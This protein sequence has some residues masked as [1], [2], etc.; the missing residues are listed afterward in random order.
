MH[1]KLLIPVLAAASLG[2]GGCYIGDFNGGMRYHRDFHYSF[3]ISAGGRVDVETFNGGIEITPWDQN[4][5]DI[6]GTKWGP[7]E[8][9]A[10][11]LR[12]ETDRTG[13]SVAVRA[14]RPSE[15]RNNLGARFSLKVPHGAVLDRIITTN[16][17]IRT[18]E[19]AGPARMQTS[20][21]S[22]HVQS[23][24]GRLDAQTSN[25]GIDV[26]DIEGDVT[27]HTSNGH[28]RAERCTGGFDASTSNGPIDFDAAG[29]LSK[30]IRAHTSNGAIT[31]HLQDPLN[32]RVLAQTSNSSIRSDFDVRMGGELTK[33]RLEGLIGSGGPDIDLS[34]SNGSI[35]ILKM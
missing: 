26:V 34:T 29:R 25:G 23:F 30:D 27:A 1:P 16:G 31:L 4:T 9:A 6:S 33:H 11:A 10:D 19:G 3:P 32:A 17:G 13:D 21:G 22:I 28:I 35:R 12:I 7:T 14:V 8:E 20:N 5:V 15:W 24:R 2:S 18:E